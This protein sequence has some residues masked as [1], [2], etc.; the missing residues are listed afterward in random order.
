LRDNFTCNFERKWDQIE[1]SL[2]FYPLIKFAAIPP[3]AKNRPW[4]IQTSSQENNFSSLE[5]KISSLAIF[6]STLVI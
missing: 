3:M 2:L 4:A 6:F 1:T 5:K